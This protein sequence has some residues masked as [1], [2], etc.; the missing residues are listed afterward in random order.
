[1]RNRWRRQVSTLVFSLTSALA[2]LWPGAS[3][4]DYVGNKY[5]DPTTGQVLEYN[6]YVPAGYDQTKKYPLMVFL[7]AANTN[8]IPPPR[9]LAS[10]GVGWTGTFLKSPYL[11][12]DPSFFMIPISQTNMSGWGEATQPISTPEKFEGELTIKVLKSDVMTKYNI[13]PNRLYITG[14]SMG[15]R[16]TWD[17]LRRYPTLFAAAAP[18]AAPASP[19][20]AALFL[21]QNIWAICGEVDP[22][23]QGERDAVDAIRKLGGNPIYTELAGHGH[24]SWRWVYPDPQ[25]VPWIYAQRLGIPWWTVSK[26]PVAPFTG[27]TPAATLTANQP[28]TMPPANLP[29]SFGGAPGS[30]GGGAGASGSG[31]GGAA[32]AAGTGGKPGGGAGGVV[33]AAGSAGPGN[34]GTGGGSGGTTPAGTGG[35]VLA[36]TGGAAPTPTSSSGG[37]PGSTTSGGV[38]TGGSGVATTGTG[39]GGVGSG[40]NQS[41]TGSS[42]G[43]GCSYGGRATRAGGLGLLAGLAFLAARRRRTHEPRPQSDPSNP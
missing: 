10:D 20:D 30:V 28:V 33:G 12:T 26:P 39:G 14:P 21:N 34:V 4:A 5:T 11:A 31:N 16:G 22:I 6:V 35:E 23:V 27:G 13:D 29:T 24:D 9:T 8:Q 37:A 40:S 32:V 19:D 38:A 18:A 36:G 41:G 25:F 42:S 15:G 43:G 3:K 7:H 17:I 2:V 1:M